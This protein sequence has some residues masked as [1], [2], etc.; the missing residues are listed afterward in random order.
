MVT[1][2]SYINSDSNESRGC[3]PTGFAAD[4][5]NTYNGREG[6]GGC[7]ND[8]L[9]SVSNNRGAASAARPSTRGCCRP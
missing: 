9:Y 3:T 4:G 8:I 2:G 7:N 1:F 6:A 5:N